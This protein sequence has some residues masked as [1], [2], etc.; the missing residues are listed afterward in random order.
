VSSVILGARTEAQ[1][2]DNLGAAGWNLS[3][4]QVA[5]LDETS[6]LPRIYPYSHQRYFPQLSDAVVL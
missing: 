6:H 3:P 2:I 1:L 5:R 4:E